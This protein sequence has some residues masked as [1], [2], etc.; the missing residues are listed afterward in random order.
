MKFSLIC[1]F[2]FT[3]VLCASGSSDLLNDSS[4][5]NDVYKG[6][7]FKI[8][9]INRYYL[10]KKFRKNLCTSSYFS[11]ESYVYFYSFNLFKVFLKLQ[12]EQDNF[13]AFDFSKKV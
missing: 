12:L 13:V 6:I 5:K 8:V 3:F 7:Y 10:L 9:L 1:V 4:E 2:C 11:L